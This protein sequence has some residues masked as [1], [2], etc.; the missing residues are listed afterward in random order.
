MN[1]FLIL[2]YGIP[3]DIKQD[4]NYITYLH[5]AFNKMYEISA[6]TEAVIIP[7]GGPTNCS[8]P[9]E[10]T[11][12][13]EMERFITD[14]M[15][16]SGI[17]EKTSAWK[18]IQENKSLSTLENFVFAKHIID[19][20]NLQGDILVFCEKTRENRI[21]AFAEKVFHQRNWT[22]E[23]VDF[24]TSKNRYLNQKTIDIKEELAMK[25]GLWVLEDPERM[26]VHHQ[27]FEK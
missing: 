11:E 5:I 19:E 10:G 9:Y 27:F 23:A 8:P 24:D 21:R 25:E 12:A 16:Q 15:G 4:K 7:C 26:K 17:Q 14:L 1:I 20:Q 18:I 3:E 13:E 2:G 6:E 22:I